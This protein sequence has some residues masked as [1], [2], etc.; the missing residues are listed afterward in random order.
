MRLGR[1]PSLLL[2]KP[3]GHLGVRVARGCGAIRS[4]APALSFGP[5][6]RESLS[7]ASP[8]T[9]HHRT[10]PSRDRRRFISG[11]QKDA[12]TLP[13]APGAAP[14]AP[15]RAADT[16][17]VSSPV[18]GGRGGLGLGTSTPRLRRLSLL[19]AAFVGQRMEEPSG[20]MGWRYLSVVE[21]QAGDPP[22]LPLLCAVP[23]W[24]FSHRV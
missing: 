19:A 3:R 7:P 14:D 12:P 24:V 1:P 17:Q 15:G 18:L 11:R 13:R 23:T 5:R 22:R 20:S 6:L 10:H 9:L 16:A 2:P 21:I 8:R 4:W